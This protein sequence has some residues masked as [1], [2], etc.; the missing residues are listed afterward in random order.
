MLR[1][2][3]AMLL[4]GL[5]TPALAA[6]QPPQSTSQAGGAETPPAPPQIPS[7]VPVAQ[8]PQPAQIEVGLDPGSRKARIVFHIG[9]QQT[10]I[11]LTRPQLEAVIGAL[12]ARD[13]ELRA[14]EGIRVPKK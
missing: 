14:L 5:V 7:A 11:D 4:A 8:I 13:A 2:T 6:D 1:F 10:E 3:Q 9:A 12:L